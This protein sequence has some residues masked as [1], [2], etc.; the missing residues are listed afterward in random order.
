MRERRKERAERREKRGER[1]KKR[2]E[3]RKERA[4]RREKRGEKDL[5]LGCLL[6]VHVAGVAHEHVHHGP[7]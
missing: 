4:E 3:R 1:R 5:V 6:R 7:L 2:G